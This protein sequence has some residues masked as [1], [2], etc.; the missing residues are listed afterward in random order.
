MI[1][2]VVQ[3][4]RGQF[5][6]RFKFE[7]ETAKEFGLVPAIPVCGRKQVMRDFPAR[8]DSALDIRQFHFVTH[9]CKCR[10][11][12]KDSFMV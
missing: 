9:L 1:L 6:P 12:R 4:G 2:C 5:F 11:R 10:R 3:Q 7:S 8:H